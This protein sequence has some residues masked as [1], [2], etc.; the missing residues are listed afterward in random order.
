MYREKNLKS[1]YYICGS[2]NNIIKTD[3]HWDSIA[4][5][6]FH[7]AIHTVVHGIVAGTRYQCGNPRVKTI[8]RY[9]YS[10]HGIP[11]PGGP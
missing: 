1:S 11:V 10:D 8:N 6:P 3:S 5:M 7:D 4:V 9:G 2:L